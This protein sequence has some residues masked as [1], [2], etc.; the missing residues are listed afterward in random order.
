MEF[1]DTHSHLYLKEFTPD[2]HETINRAIL[3]NICKIVLPNIDSE[4]IIPLHDLTNK[5][6]DSL[7]PLMGLHPTYVKENFEKELEVIFKQFETFPYKG[8]GEIG[9]DHYWDLTYK[10]E[11][12]I[13]F[14]MQL[15]FALK[16]NLPVVIHARDSFR[17]ILDVIKTPEYSTLYG[18]FH[19]FTGDNSLAEEIIG[20][21]FKLGIGGIVTFKNSGLSEVIKKTGIEHLVLETDS[22][23]LAPVPYRGKRNESSY[24]RLIAER[25]AEIKDI[26]L[27]KV[28]EI[29]TRNAKEIFSI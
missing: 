3:V 27:E 8:M 9:I 11:Q 21:G 1:I 17:E 12:L 28:A 18:I 7:I 24:I 6:P 19:A 10:E 2:I 14:K 20:L 5:Y 13:A 26:P 22:P 29:T 25:I 23:Y 15:D 16:M 4:S